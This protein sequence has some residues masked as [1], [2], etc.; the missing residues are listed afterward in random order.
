MIILRLRDYQEDG[1][2][3]ILDKLSENQST[4]A[5]L[6]TG[7]GKT[8]LLAA[9]IDAF[10]PLRSLVIAHREELI[11]QARE[12]IIATTGLDCSIE[13]GELTASKMTKTPVVIATVQTL[14]SALGDRTRMSLFDPKEFGLLVIDEGHHSTAQTYRNVIHYFT[15]NNPKLK[16]LGVTATPDRGDEEALGQIFQTVAYEYSILDAIHDGWLVPVEQQMVVIEDFDIS[17]VRT[18]DGDLNG[19]ELALVMEAERNL[20]GVAGASI[21]IIGD[22][23][24]IV[25]TVSV[26]QAE[27][28]CDIFNRH[29]AGM[30]AWVCGKTPKDQR[31]LLLEDFKSGRIQVLC[32]CNCFTEGFDCPEVEVVV[33]AA[34]TKSRARYAQRA[35]RCMRPL[36]GVVDPHPTR[37]TRKLAIAMSKKPSCLMLDF[38]GD[39]GRH[40][41]VTTADILS[42]NVSEEAAKHAYETAKKANGPVNMVDLLKDEEEAIRKKLEQQRLA[43]RARKE[44]LLAKVQ[45]HTKVVNAFDVMD[46]NPVRKGAWDDV[47]VLSEKGS[48]FLVKQGFNPD[49]YTYSQAVALIRETM[50]RFKGQL[51][52]PKQCSIIKQYHPELNTSNMTALEA[53]RI[54]DQIAKQN[55][56]RNQ[57][58]AP[59]RN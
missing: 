13:M 28:L 34:P 17:H 57:V 21:P 10:Q 37:G 19:K 7:T 35:G 32:N 43:E 2:R 31:R 8:P 5:V 20:Q 1:K 38:A 53:S 42:G 24:A 40:K 6:P 58:P 33:M 3:A 47:R 59:E 39:S 18:T 48:L 22:K 9:V 52:R 14:N 4:L 25:F 30:C 44:N 12:R 51:A 29:R 55:W 36:A 45:Y 23:R 26:K 11:F 41:L 27:I 15:T 46:I 54:I 50:R 56:R 49:D 16:V